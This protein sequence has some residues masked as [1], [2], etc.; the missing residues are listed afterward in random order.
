MET[1]IND[2][3]VTKM[4]SVTK[5]LANSNQKII[6]LEKTVGQHATTLDNDKMTPGSNDVIITEIASITERL[7]KIEQNLQK[8]DKQQTQLTESLQKT[9]IESLN[10]KKLGHHLHYILRKF[11]LRFINAD[12]HHDF[13]EFKFYISQETQMLTDLLQDLP[14]EVDALVNEMVSINRFDVHKI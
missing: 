7:A 12:C 13:K 2:D 5:D 11:I 8:T 6:N 3:L 1:E 14:D 10:S 9:E 4:V